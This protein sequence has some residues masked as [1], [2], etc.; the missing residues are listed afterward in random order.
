MLSV[1]LELLECELGG[2][3]LYSR[4]LTAEE[5]TASFNCPTSSLDDSF[6][7]LIFSRLEEV[8]VS[9]GQARLRVHSAG[10]LSLAPAEYAYTIG[11]ALSMP[12]SETW[13]QALN[14]T[15]AGHHE[16]VCP[17]LF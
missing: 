1:K 8:E 3:Y 11:Q 5:V 10:T 7:V 9:Q 15:I 4:P 16:A 17:L 2:V 14:G 13:G 6:A 12:K